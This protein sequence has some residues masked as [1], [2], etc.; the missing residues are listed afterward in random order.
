MLLID[1]FCVYSSMHTI[2]YFPMARDWKTWQII[3]IFLHWAFTL[4]LSVSSTS[5]IQ[6][7]G[8]NSVLL[9]SAVYRLLW[10]VVETDD[11]DDED[12]SIHHDNNDIYY[13]EGRIE[14]WWCGRGFFV[15]VNMSKLWFCIHE[16]ME[17]IP[18]H[19]EKCFVNIRTKTKRKN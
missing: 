6:S 19:W 10:N 15:C 3:L 18:L 11:D 7:N 16:C 13:V 17:N 2:H 8:L 4:L 14:A 5:V 12:G 9:G 1:F